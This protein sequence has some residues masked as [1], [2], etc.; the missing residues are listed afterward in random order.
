MKS[1]IYFF[2]LLSR[3]PKDCHGNSNWICHHGLHW[4]LCQTHP[5]PH[6]QHHCVSNPHTKNTITSAIQTFIAVI[7]KNSWL[8][9]SLNSQHVIYYRALKIMCKL[10]FDLMLCY[11]QPLIYSVI[12]AGLLFLLTVVVEPAVK[13]NRP[14]AAG[15]DDGLNANICII[16]AFCAC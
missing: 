11:I 12:K 6:Q 3:I 14:A 2:P 9:K 5:H 13:P 15:N 16:H 10:P 7:V 1:L 4:I 8:Q